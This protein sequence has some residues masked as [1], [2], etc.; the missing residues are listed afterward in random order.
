MVTRKAPSPIESEAYAAAKTNDL[1]R[2]KAT[3]EAH[4]KVDPELKPYGQGLLLHAVLNG[5]LET[6]RFLLD[7]GFDANEADPT[8][9]TPLHGAAEY[10]NLQLVKLLLEHG[11]E[12]NVKDSRGNTPLSKA[13][14]VAGEDLSVVQALIAGGADPKFVFHPGMDA[15]VMAEKIGKPEIARYLE[16]L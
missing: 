13:I 7:N 8:G 5:A 12:C 14:F 15:I 10:Q 6:A 11:A 3:F 2:L 16:S 1:A 9:T 4:G